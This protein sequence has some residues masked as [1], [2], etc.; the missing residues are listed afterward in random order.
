MS[1]YTKEFSM[2]KV[3]LSLIAVL[4]LLSC[5]AQTTQIKKLNP[6][7]F[8]KQVSKAIVLLDVRTAAEFRAGHIAG[9]LQADWTNPKEFSERVKFIDKTATIYIY[10]AAGPR[11][12]AAAAWL[13]ENG[14]NNVYELNGGFISW[15]RNGKPVEASVTTQ[16]QMTLEEYKASVSSA[17]TI[18][19]DFG[20]AWCPPCVKME[21]VLQEVR[22][23]L[24]DKFTL[25]KVEAGIH[26]D[27]QVALHI[28]SYPTFIIYK[29]GKESW[30]QSGLVEKKVLIEQL[31]R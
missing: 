16:Q 22:D 15:K 5:N 3:L 11:S 13:M 10:C 28:D 2:Y 14:Y 23:T 9:A 29:N 25:L 18:L 26:T 19:V 31:G 20:A 6:D 12:T 27:I 24:A 30:R 17:G 1:V 21:P 8:E 4:P 7:E